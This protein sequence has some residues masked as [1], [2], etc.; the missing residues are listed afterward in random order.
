LVWKPEK[1]E[2]LEDQKVYGRIILKLCSIN[3][4]GE[5]GIAFIWLR[6]GRIVELLYRV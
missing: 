1:R 5:S 4:V 2:F 3:R 6:V